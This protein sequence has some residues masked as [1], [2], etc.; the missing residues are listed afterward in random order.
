[1]KK[2]KKILISQPEPQSKNNPYAE[3][4][5]KH[6]IKIK[7]DPLIEIIGLKVRDIRLQKINVNNF[8]AIIFT[9]RIAIDH[10]F[11]ICE[12]MRFTVPNTMKYFCVSE[13]ISFY[14][15]KYTAYRKR[16]IYVGG[17]KFEDLLELI[18]KHNT[19]K[20]LLPSAEHTNPKTIEFLDNLEIDYTRGIFFK[21]VPKKSTIKRFSYD[22]VVLF[23]PI[24]ID[25]I[26][27][28]FSDLFEKNH[29]ILIACFGNITQSYAESKDL[30]VS[31]KAPNDK[32]LS[33]L[34]CLDYFLSK[35]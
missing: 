1:M 18:E 12:E 11:R 19:E 20:F 27:Q 3:L 26:I 9:S 25:S 8:S 24:D 5:K 33:M 16:K 2:I 31:L 28:N 17:K 34:S 32:N 35:K 21:T 15:Q 13:A 7:F 4:A 14:L 10:F 22:M 23:S 6:N 30:T 29:D